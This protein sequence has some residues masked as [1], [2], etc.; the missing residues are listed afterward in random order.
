[1]SPSRY[2]QSLGKSSNRKQLRTTCRNKARPPCSRRGRRTLSR[3][4]GSRPRLKWSTWS[5]LMG[6]REERSW[7]SLH[8]EAPKLGE[9]W[10]G[11]SEGLSYFAVFPLW[12]FCVDE[13]DAG[14]SSPACSISMPAVTVGPN[15]GQNRTGLGRLRGAFQGGLSC[16]F[17][18]PLKRFLLS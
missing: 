6:R 2:Y 11:F 9:M 8:T 12:G 3:G 15:G 1:M 4:Q 10:D 5:C 13:R 18:P 16:N 7:R 14:C 17:S